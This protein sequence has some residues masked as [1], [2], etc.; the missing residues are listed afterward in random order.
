MYFF[1][2]FYLPECRLLLWLVWV[3][4]WRLYQNTVRPVHAGSSCYVELLPL[5]GNHPPESTVKLLIFRPSF[6]EKV[7]LSTRWSYWTVKI[8]KTFHS[9][10]PGYQAMLW[11]AWVPRMGTL[12]TLFHFYMVFFISKVVVFKDKWQA[13]KYLCFIFS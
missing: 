8:Q 13:K 12:R 11:I 7:F 9:R 10:Y 5:V 4:H 6:K 1:D 3:E 2:W